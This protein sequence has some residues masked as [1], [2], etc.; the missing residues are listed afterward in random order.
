MGRENGELM[1]CKDGNP[2][3]RPPFVSFYASIF[4]AIF[5]G[6]IFLAIYSGLYMLL[7]YRCWGVGL[8]WG[9]LFLALVYSACARANALFRV[10]LDSPFG[11]SHFA[12]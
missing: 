9:H 8:G 3:F 10:R 2:F 4:L 11:F 1:Q 6:T 5:L 7:C 12:F